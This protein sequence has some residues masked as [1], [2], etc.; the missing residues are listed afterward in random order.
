MPNDG[1]QYCCNYGGN[2]LRNVR[3]VSIAYIVASSL[4]GIMQHEEIRVKQRTS[5]K[6]C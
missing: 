5:R 4:V 3:F 2:S 1:C 6:V